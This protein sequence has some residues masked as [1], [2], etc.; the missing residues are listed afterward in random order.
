ML[1]DKIWSVKPKIIYVA[2]NPKDVAISFFHHY[3][4][5]VGYDG[6][7]EYFIEAFLN[8]KV[9]YAPFND[10]VMDFWKIRD[11]SNILFLHYEDMKRHMSDVI[12][13]TM[14]FLG[15]DYNQSQIDELS[16]HLSIESM[17]NNKMCN[18]DELVAKVKELNDNGKR[19]GEFR[20]IRK[21]QIGAYKD[22]LSYDTNQKFDLYMAAKS[23]KSQNFSYKI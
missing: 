9:I 4:H 10:H 16:A 18:N 3:R 6:P 7:Q 21:G 19:A 1:P 17:R 12:R 23:L 5:I 2:R 22:E 14:K 15:K 20:F 8:D 13:E 11:R